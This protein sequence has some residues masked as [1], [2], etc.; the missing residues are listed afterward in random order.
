MVSGQLEAN[1]MPDRVKRVL[2]DSGNLVMSPNN[3][4]LFGTD[5]RSDVPGPA[6]ADT[7]LLMRYGGGKAARVSVPRDTLVHIP[8]YGR[9]KIN[10]AFAFGGTPLLIT[11]IKQYL[12]IEINHVAKIDFKGFRRFVDALGGVK[13][14]FDKC[15]VSH[16]DGRLR[17]VGCEGDFRACKPKDGKVHIDGR[18]ALN[19]V[20]IRRNL[21]APKDSDYSRV[22]RQQSFLDAVRG[23]ILSPLSIP[24]WPWAAWRAPRAM[25]TDMNG[26]SLFA[27]FFDSAI[28]QSAEPHVLRPSGVNRQGAIIVSEA[29]KQAAV[30]RFLE[31]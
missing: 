7:I 3:I 14:N 10:A 17:H 5:R 28:F 2:D 21:C 20:R 30:K 19:V 4:L 8:G 18:A 9:N 12:R 16:F 25:Q 29:E 1:E 6:R 11:T 26:P 31:G 22:R 24:R 13:M 15:L 23:R 27:L